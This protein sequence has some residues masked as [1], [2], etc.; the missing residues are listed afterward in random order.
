MNPRCL[1]L[2]LSSCCCCCCVVV[3]VVVVVLL[4]LLYFVVSVFFY[5]GRFCYLKI[6]G[7]DMN[8]FPF[9]ERKNYGGKL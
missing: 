7:I 1:D 5:K 8:I 4:L 6:G 2:L 9:I 3:V